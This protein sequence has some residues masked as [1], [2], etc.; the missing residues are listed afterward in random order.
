[1]TAGSRKRNLDRKASCCVLAMVEMKS[2]K[3]RPATEVWEMQPPCRPGKHGRLRVDVR[4]GG[5]MVG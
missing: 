2:P 4:Q 3:E 5:R 1:M